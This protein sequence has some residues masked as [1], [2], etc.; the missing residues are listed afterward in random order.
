MQ[1]PTN[2]QAVAHPQRFRQRERERLRMRMVM[3]QRGQGRKGPVR[4]DPAGQ[5]EE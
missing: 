2:W 3:V 5:R 1:G 4:R